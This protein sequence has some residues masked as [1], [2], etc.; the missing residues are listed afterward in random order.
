MGLLASLQTSRFACM[1]A[2]L[3]I[4]V[5]TQHTYMYI[6]MYM[7]TCM[8]AQ[9]HTCTMYMCTCMYAQTH[10]CT[11]YMCTCTHALLCVAVC[12]DGALLLAA[13]EL[14]MCQRWPG[15][16]CAHVPHAVW[17]GASH[18]LFSVVSPSPY[19]VWSIFKILIP[20]S[21]HI[22]SLEPQRQLQLLKNDNDLKVH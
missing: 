15:T 22:E 20:F 16:D 3:H 2:C 7:C 19:R 14:P 21:R 9:T 11:M 12:H 6:Y 18:T 8:Y 1:Y 5:C 4:R 17:D 10:T 13:I